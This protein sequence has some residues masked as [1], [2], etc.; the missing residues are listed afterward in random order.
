MECT[1][2][3][4]VIGLKGIP[5]V[6]KGDNLSEIIVST[7]EKQGVA[8]EDGDILVVTQKIVSKAEGRVFRL[9][10]KASSEFAR[11]IA[12]AT[13]HE[14][15]HI[16]FILQ[17][18]AR[19]VRMNGAHLIMETKQGFVCAN[20][21]VDKSNVPGIDE[22]A[23]L[24]A[25]PDLSAERIRNGIEKR[26]G[27]KLAVIVSDTWGRPWRLGQVNFA[28][29]V[30][31]MC[32]LRDYRGVKDMFGYELRVTSIAVADELA[33]TGELVMNKVDAG[34]VAVIKGYSYPPGDGSGKDLIRPAESD[35]FR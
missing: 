6:K 25:D 18:S 26:L 17:E 4:T 35:L 2:L 32:P 21:G 28:I 27:T 8:L 15:S 12:T 5:I 33:A 9:T 11:N 29:G 7:A 19:A 13:Q 24:P 16:E 20:A 14:P 31:G 3:L 34:P 30:A 22:I 23:L 1:G 10:D